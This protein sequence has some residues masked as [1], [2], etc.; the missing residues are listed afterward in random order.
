M[1]HFVICCLSVIF[2]YFAHFLGISILFHLS[3]AF[4]QTV[5][6]LLMFTLFYI[7]LTFV[8]EPA[9][10]LLIQS[11][12]LLRFNR[13]IT[14][15]AAEMI[16]IGCLWAAIYTADELLDDVLLTTSAEIMIA[17]SFFTIDKILYP[18]QRSGS[19][20]Y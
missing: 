20:S 7:V 13:R 3:G 18:R 4:Y 16:T 1:K 11:I 9:E 10:K 5:G 2:V 15:F 8:M 17:V 12:Q 14:F 6:S 19:L